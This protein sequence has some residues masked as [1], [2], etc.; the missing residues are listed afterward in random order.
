MKKCFL[1]AVAFTAAFQLT[2]DVKMPAIFSDNMVL[3]QGVAAPVW[4]KA[5]PGEKVTVS[6]GGSEVSAV[7]DK[8]GKWMVKLP[9]SKVS[10]QAAEMKISGKN[11]ITIK[12]ILV[13]N[14]WLAS[15]QSNMEFPLSR[16]NNAKEVMAKANYPE[17][18]YFLVRKNPQLTPQDDCQGSWQIITPA[19]SRLMS[20]VAYF[21]ALDLYQTFK[22]P[23]GVICSYWGGTN[24]KVW[25]SKEK[26]AAELPH[27]AQAL[28]KHI[29]DIPAYTRRYNEKLM[30]EYEKK[31]AQWQEDR[32]NNPKLRRPYPPQKPGAASNVPANLFNGMI[33]P[34]IPY[35]ITGVIWYQGEANAG[36]P[37][38][39]VKLMEALISDW[40]ER[41]GLGDFPFYFVQLANFRA[42]AKEPTRWKTWANLREAQTI[43]RDT[44]KNTGMAVIIDVGETNDIH[45][46]D[47]QT[48][49]K[50]LALLE[51]KR[52]GM[53]VVCR[54]PSFDKMNITDGKAVISFDNCKTLKTK[55]GG[56]KVLGFAIAG[57]DKVFHW[58]DAVLDGNTVVVSSPD[59]KKPVAVRY[60]WENNPDTNLHNEAGLPAEPFRTDK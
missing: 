3:Q 22:Q 28:E 50:R 11:S 30:P 9:A 44:I 41:F 32:K 42:K 40:R 38:E 18:R 27:Y 2:A 12:N 7:A 19:S 36:A 33:N 47:K 21:F 53:D 56:K 14:V 31:F 8:D 57:S 6:F 39:Y 34:V 20:G 4:G 13:G 16:V 46:K 29:A 48:V 58:A 24:A 55:D 49:G 15:G 52:Q 43:N 51:K 1:A 45:P 17:I 35:A 60:A 10:G 26:L 54:G 5:D 23:V 59:V 37:E 25:V